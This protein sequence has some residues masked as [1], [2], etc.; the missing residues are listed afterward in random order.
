MKLFFEFFPIVLFFVT[1]KFKGIFIATEVAIAASIVQMAVTYWIKKKIEPMLII[2]VVILV[3]F[4]GSTILLHNELFIKWKPTVLYWLFTVILFTGHFVFKKNLIRKL[5]ESQLQLPDPVW[6]KLNLSWM[7]FF[8][9]LG[10]LNLFVAYRF[11]TDIWVNFKLFGILGC[12]F[13]FAI[14]QGVFLNKY[15]DTDKPDSESSE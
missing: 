14:G 10:G 12:I 15:I 11:P 4:G 5:L 3:V 6:K 13:V 9:V 7:V 8:A 2:S 1:Y